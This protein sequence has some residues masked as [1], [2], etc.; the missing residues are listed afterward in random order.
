MTTSF[1]RPSPTRPLLRA[2]GPSGRV[3]RIPPHR[4]DT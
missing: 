1:S 4:P 2:V 3:E